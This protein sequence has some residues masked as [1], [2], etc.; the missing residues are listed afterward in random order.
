MFSDAGKVINPLRA[1]GQD[2]GGAVMAIGAAFMEKLII[3]D[4]GVIL[5]AGS[6]DYKVPHD[7]AIFPTRWKP[8][9]RKTRT[10]PALMG[11]RASEKAGYWRPCRQS[12]RPFT[13]P[14]GLKVRE[15]PITPEV[16]VE[17]EE[18]K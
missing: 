17:F 11:P 18:G 15:I 4:S 3:N 12:A 9:F 7:R 8:F 6:L 16:F 5:N 14:R 2:E 1:V 13:M 10:A